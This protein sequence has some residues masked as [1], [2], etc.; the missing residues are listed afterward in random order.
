MTA[1]T[2]D[3][4]ICFEIGSKY[5]GS[6]LS[7]ILVIVGSERKNGN[8]KILAEHFAK[9]AGVHNKVEIVTVSDYN[10]CPCKGCN[11]CYTSEGNKCCI[12]DDMN[13]IYDKL[14]ST[15]ILIMASPVYFYGIS[16]QLKSIVDRLHT[17]MRKTF[18]VRKLGLLLVAATDIP[19]LFDPII[20][21]YDMVCAFFKLESVGIVTAGGVKDEGDIIG[22]D[23]LS[24]AY[25][26][27]KKIE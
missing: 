21:Q 2:Y 15:D 5:E 4:L 17:P 22:K 18:K 6:R 12:E 24:S 13:L 9:G 8:T 16:S 23:A 27:G 20:M 11:Y 25:E 1:Y 10:I 26:M 14:R 7:N 3:N 19:K